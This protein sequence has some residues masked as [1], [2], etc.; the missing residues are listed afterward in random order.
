VTVNGDVAARAGH[1]VATGDLVEVRVPPPAPSRAEA[2]EIPLAVLYQDAHLIVIDKPAGLVVH[3]APGH[4]AGTLVNALLHHAGD[5]AGVG[6]ELRPG[7]VH[8]LDKDT[9]G[10]MVA[11]KDDATHQRLV[12]M[13]Q[14]RDLDREYI[15]VVAPP[16]KT[17]AGVFDTL[18]GRHPTDRK[19]FTTRVTRG[20]RAVTRFRL[21]EVLAG[22]QAALVRCRLETGRTH[23]IRVHFAEAGS[24]L[25]GDPVYGRGRKRPAALA[26]AAAAL[27]RQA[28][29]AAVLGFVHPITG[30]PL[31]F[32]SEPPEDLA[33][34]IETLR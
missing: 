19:R 15:A 7:I 25:L 17:S 23:Q 4:P 10:V 6:G 5:L 11:S 33:R 20:K 29:H 30:A 21:E 34:L 31:R 13:F 26:A 9:S 1:R 8:R 16:P 27:G 22:G 12:E 14:A 18:H 3:P 24:P 28:L 32:E 2:E